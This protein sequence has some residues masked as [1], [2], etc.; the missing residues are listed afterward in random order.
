MLIL[1]PPMSQIK[2]AGSE[3]L[4]NFIFKKENPDQMVGVFWFFSVELERLS[5]LQKSQAGFEDG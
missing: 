2:R 5:P 1:W 3:E 4:A